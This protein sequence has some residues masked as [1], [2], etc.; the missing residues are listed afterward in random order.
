M[1]LVYILDDSFELLDMYQLIFTLHNFDC[2]TSY[3]KPE[4]L[5]LLKANKPDIILLDVM[6]GGEDGREICRELKQD[7]EYKDIPVILISANAKNLANYE[8]FS[9]DGISEKPFNVK[10][11]IEKVNRLI[12]AS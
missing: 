4:F 6:L 11:L 8:D 12:P 9:A 2:N 10:E 5:N 3:N 7:N 1:P